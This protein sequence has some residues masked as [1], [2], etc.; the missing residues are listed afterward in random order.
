MVVSCIKEALESHFCCLSLMGKVDQEDFTFV[1]PD[2]HYLHFFFQQGTVE[3]K[4]GT[5]VLNVKSSI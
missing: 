3:K 2:Y 4:V 1:F 5:K